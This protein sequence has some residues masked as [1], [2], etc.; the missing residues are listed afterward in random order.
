[1]GSALGVA[2]DNFR[3]RTGEL[4]YSSSRQPGV[5]A[6]LRGL[7]TGIGIVSDYARPEEDFSMH[8][9]V[10]NGGLTPPELLQA[11]QATPLTSSG[12]Q[13]QGETVV[14][15]EGTPV[16]TS[17]V[18]AFDQKFGLPPAQ[19]QIVGGDAS[20]KA[21]SSGEPDMDIETVHEIAPMAKLVYFDA[22]AAPGVTNSM[23]DA[24]A[25]AQMIADMGS[26]YKGAIISMSL[27]FCEQ[28]FNAADIQ[29]ISSAAQVAES[30]GS[31]VY[32]SSGDAGGADCGNFGADSLT[33]AEG[34]VFPAVAPNVTGVGGTTLSVTPSGG[35]VGE[36]TW[37]SPMMSQGGGGGVSAIVP[38]P[39]W[40]AGPGVG[41][42][43]IA[44]MREVPDVAA[45][46]DPVT[47]TAF[48]T[49]GQ[50]ESGGG[51]SLSAPIWAGFTALID[52]YLGSNNESPVGF[53]NP[54]LYRLGDDSQLSPSPFHQVTV[55][56]NV[57]YQAGP[58]YN[59]VTGLG[60]P[61]V[62][63]LATY[64]LDIDKTG[65]P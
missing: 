45:D 62:A 42:Q 49:N 55:G 44:D 60:T 37:S 17:D 30:N 50:L 18:T 54:I 15:L 12:D 36:T 43:G 8:D 7:V 35:Y 25:I 33:S 11:Y 1:M 5:P 32:A 41:G 40:Q 51:T 16:E 47:G 65:N 39:S 38:R 48:I 34:V 26:E 59:A 2:V 64:I 14:F 10:P 56:G 3:S 28:G 9:Y 20:G 57:F 22:N 61:N 63:A 27:G 4:F 53:A 24:A 58:G 29:A 31:S 13:G 52:E 6:S 21:S 23:D 19:L 46:A